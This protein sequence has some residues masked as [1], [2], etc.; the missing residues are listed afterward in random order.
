MHSLDS[1]SSQRQK[2]DS[3]GRDIRRGA[4]APEAATREREPVETCALSARAPNPFCFFSSRSQRA[5][6]LSALV[7]DNALPEGST[8]QQA[9]E[10][11]R[12][13]IRLVTL[14]GSFL[15]FAS[16]VSS[17]PSLVL[18]IHTN[19]VLYSE[20]QAKKLVC[21]QTR[22]VRSKY[23]ILYVADALLLK[24]LLL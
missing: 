2:S 13:G 10:N 16:I 15:L 4:K 14:T 1:R 12:E 17:T 20:A 5:F 23:R 22:R 19:T 11:T 9:P 8:G 21:W 3:F 24:K 6:S 7:K 18:Q